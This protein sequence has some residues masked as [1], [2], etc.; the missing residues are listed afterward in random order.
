[1]DDASQDNLKM[2]IKVWLQKNGK[3]YGW[4]AQKCFVSESTVRNWMARKQIPAVKEHLIRE[5]TK[6]VSLIHPP[7]EVAEETL[8]SLRLSSDMKRALEEKAFSQGKTLKEYLS[9][10]INKLI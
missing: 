1:M 8:I 3:D 9:D 10:A 5:I 2:D 6:H 7:V 4:L